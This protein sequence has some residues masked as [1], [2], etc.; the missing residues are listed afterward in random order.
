MAHH[1]SALKRLRQNAKRRAR[2]RYYRSWMRTLIKKVR[3]AQT[4]AEALPL[5]NQAK[6]LLDR[7]VVKGIIHKNKAANY[8]RKLEKHV[9]QLA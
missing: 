8:K 7:L 2:N 4:K 3:A 5:L 1:K 6:S 9:N